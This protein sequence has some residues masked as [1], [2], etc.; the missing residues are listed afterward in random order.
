M[1]NYKCTHTL[2]YLL[3]ESRVYNIKWMDAEYTD[4]NNKTLVTRA[5][6]SLWCIVLQNGDILTNSAL[7]FVYVFWHE[8]TDDILAKIRIRAYKVKR[9]W[10]N[11]RAVYQWEQRDWKNQLNDT[12][13]KI[14]LQRSPTTSIWSR[15]FVDLCTCLTLHY[16]L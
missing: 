5:A 11:Y 10:L 2:K 6:A 16:S 3:T 15:W 12:D 13:N 14:N 9:L 7:D 1:N 4:P 8:L